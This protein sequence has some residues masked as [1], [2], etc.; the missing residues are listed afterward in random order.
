MRREDLKKLFKD[1][2]TDYQID[3]LIYTFLF[4]I[5]PIFFSNAQ[6]QLNNFGATEIISTRPGYTKFTV[7]D[8]NGDGIKDVILF[9][10]Q[11]KNFTIHF[12]LKDSTFTKG[13][14]K[15]F[16]YPIDEF[17][18]F[19]KSKDGRDYYIFTSRNLRIVGLVSFTKS[20]SLLLLNTLRFDSYPSEISVLD[21]DNNGKNEAL[22]YGNNFNGI[23]KIENNNY[24]LNYQKMIDNK[25]VSNLHLLDFNQDQYQDVLISDVLSNEIQFWENNEGNE[26]VESRKMKIEATILNFQLLDLNDDYFKDIILT[27]E[28]LIN[29]Y[30]GDSVYSFENYYSQNVATYPENLLV[31]DLNYDEIKELSYIDEIGNEFVWHPNLD[32]LSIGVNYFIE[33]IT[34]TKVIQIKGKEA[35]LALS[36]RGKLQLFYSNNLNND[37]VNF[38]I[39]EQIQKISGVQNILDNHF[40]FLKNAKDNAYSLLTLSSNNF[41][42]LGTIPLYSSFNEL[43]WS[44][45]INTLVALNKGEKT[46]EIIYNFKSEEV[47]SRQH[48]YYSAFPTK[49]VSVVSDTISVLEVNDSLLYFEKVIPDNDKYLQDTL[50]LIDSTYNKLL[51]FEGRVYYTI[52]YDNFKIL[53]QY[54]HQSY[55][56]LYKIDVTKFEINNEKIITS[57]NSK[58]LAYIASSNDKSLVILVNRRATLAYNL[59]EKLDADSKLSLFS[60][61]DSPTLFEY[62]IKKKKLNKYILKNYEKVI[63]PILVFD[64]LDI[65]DYFIIEIKNNI[66]LVY[67][68]IDQN[69]ITFKKIK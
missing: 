19:N 23:V 18:Y 4:L 24:L 5:T 34:F 41:E 60:L 33:G 9:G 16:F 10:N 20:S 49:D 51:L 68:S 66:Y 65:N 15:F 52:N 40:I 55:N 67:T 54:E 30:Y 32:T 17:K 8:F 2:K 26:L 58:E 61:D 21:M 42:A 50:I 37:E 1:V 38:S 44:N 31:S 46:L 35:L 56:E 64:D 22:V 6:V 48:F 39:G 3:K 12:G 62:N 69:F 28:G 63:E 53:K 36:R 25:V 29:I 57:S 47:K 7:H 11:R 27:S 13:L 43:S 45:S 59:S 14:S